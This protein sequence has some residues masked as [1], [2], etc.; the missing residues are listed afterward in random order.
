MK[1]TTLQTLKEC[2]KDPVTFEKLRNLF[3]DIREKAERFENFLN[4]LERSIR[5]DYDA[6]MITEPD[7]EESG[8]KIVYVNDKFTQ[9]TGYTRDEV[10]GETTRILQGPKTDR[11]V[12]DKMKKCI[13]EGRSFFGHTVNY[14]KD[15]TEFVNQW[16]IH[17]LT[18]ENGEV[19]HW[20]S[21]QNDITVRERPEK[22]PAETRIDFENRSSQKRVLQRL[23]QKTREVERIFEISTDYSYKARRKALSDL[24]I[25]YLSDGFFNMNRN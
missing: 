4:L 20:I 24:N 14:R 8:L 9:I 2:S 11:V 16:D 23:E 13:L 17:P 10:V 3:D 19:S 18:D 6:I 12:L 21:Y 25:D 7:Y 15:G 1:Q 5:N 22:T